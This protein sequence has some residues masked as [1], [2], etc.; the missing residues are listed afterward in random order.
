MAFSF[1]GVLAPFVSTVGGVAALRLE[2]ATLRFAAA[3][4]DGGVTGDS[5][6]GGGGRGGDGGGRGRA[7]AAVVDMVDFGVRLHGDAAAA[8]WVVS[9]VEP[10][11]SYE[12]ALLTA[13][14]PDVSVAAGPSGVSLSRAGGRSIETARPPYAVAATVGTDR[15]A[16]SADWRWE[17]TGLDD[18]SPY[19]AHRGGGGGRR[20][21]AGHGWRHAASAA[22][23]PAAATQSHAAPAGALH[24]SW[25]A[26]AAGAA[27]AAELTFEVYARPRVVRWPRGGLG[28]TVR[29]AL[30]RSEPRIS[31]GMEYT[32]AFTIPLPLG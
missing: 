23:A 14:A 32:Q 10:R 4:V 9:A 5:G 20:R 21:A 30:S 29:L 26:P 28:A 7:P 25:T 22:A 16:H 6:G 27:A 2:W 17:L 15:V 1:L 24:A 11:P 8:G 31:G 12:V 18:G 13:A 19:Y 3:P